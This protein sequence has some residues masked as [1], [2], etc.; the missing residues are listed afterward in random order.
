MKELQLIQLAWWLCTLFRTKPYLI[1]YFKLERVSEKLYWHCTLESVRE[2]IHKA[3]GEARFYMSNF[4]KAPWHTLITKPVLPDFTSTYI[5]TRNYALKEK[6]TA[7]H[8][9]NKFRR[10]SKNS[11]CHI[12]ILFLK[13][14]KINPQCLN[15]F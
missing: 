8:L 4:A 5:Q 9:Q 10:K 15:K 3:E 13:K 14:K 11:S 6:R 1:Q 12:L 7:L 2:D